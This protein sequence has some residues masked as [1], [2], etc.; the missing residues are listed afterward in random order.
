MKIQIYIPGPLVTGGPENCHQIADGLLRL[1]V[2][3][4]IQYYKTD[5]R[6]YEPIVWDD[7]NPY[8]SRYTMI[9]RRP[10]DQYEP[11]HYIF[12]SVDH[13]LRDLHKGSPRA[14]HWN[15]TPEYCRK[16]IGLQKLAVLLFGNKSYAAAMAGLC[17]EK[18]NSKGF[19]Q[20]RAAWSVRASAGDLLHLVQSYSA[21]YQLK[22]GYG[23]DPVFLFDYCHKQFFDTVDLASADMVRDI[24][25]VY[26]P[27]SEPHAS[28]VLKKMGLKTKLLKGLSRD[29]L[30]LTLKRSKCYLDLGNH[31][32][33][34]RLPREAVVCGAVAVI[35]HAGTAECFVDVPSI[36]DLKVKRSNYMGI[37]NAIR[38]VIQNPDTYRQRQQY[39]ALDIRKQ[40]DE[41]D[42]QLL[43]FLTRFERSSKHL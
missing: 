18:I 26:Q 10:G 1:G 14:V 31:P 16:F 37:R 7:G 39:F 34:D 23:F 9:Q 22:K 40:R 11:T 33:R 30:I 32:G 12:G 13:R 19:L 29:E 6:I 20:K 42:R 27:R 43:G 41:F 4:R 24:D 3:C 25:V 17:V 21:Y 38:A 36:P 28:L 2:E 5:A 35:G 8:V 15:V